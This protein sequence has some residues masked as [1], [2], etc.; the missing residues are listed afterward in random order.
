M[1]QKQ[2]KKEWIHHNTVV[3]MFYYKALTTVPSNGKHPQNVICIIRNEKKKEYPLLHIE[4]NCHKHMHN[5]E[6]LLKVHP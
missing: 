6:V 2:A 5:H 3:I 4:N 1:W